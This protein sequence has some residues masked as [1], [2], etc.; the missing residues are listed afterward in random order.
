MSV[1][2]LLV[3]LAL[4]GV[5]GAASVGLGSALIGGVGLGVG[6]A[7]K[8]ILAEGL[9]GVEMICMPTQ[10]RDQKRLELILTEMGCEISY[11]C[12][13]MVVWKDE[14]L[15]LFDV[16]KSEENMAF[17]AFTAKA[18]GTDKLQAMVD[19]INKACIRNVQ[20]EVYQNLMNNAKISGMQIESEEIEDDNTVVLTFVIEG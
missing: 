20:D 12:E 8:E 11:E 15:Y 18:T 2:I 10:I 9:N 5:G 3:P 4:G 1:V 13:K 14:N 7:A 17:H 16:M 19:E 6:L